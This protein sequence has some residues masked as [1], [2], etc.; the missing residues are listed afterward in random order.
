M[1]AQTLV[2]ISPVGVVGAVNEKPESVVHVAT[3]VLVRSGAIVVRSQSAAL[4]T[5]KVAARAKIENFMVGW[6]AGWKGTDLCEV[7]WGMRG[8]LG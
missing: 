2:S 3:L 5:A 8:A 1:L 6:R 7:N 4:T